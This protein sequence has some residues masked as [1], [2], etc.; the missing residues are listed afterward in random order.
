MKSLLA[1]GTLFFALTFCG[2]TDKIKEQVAETS[3][4]ADGT[5]KPD[6]SSGDNTDTGKTETD[7]GDKVEK[8]N[9]TAKQQEII[10]NG[11]KVVWEEQGMGF[12]LPDGWNKMR[13]GKKMFQYGSPA[14]GFLIVN[15]SSLGQNF[16]TDVS[17]KAFYDQ[18]VQ[19]K[20]DGDV[21]LVRYM[22]IDNIKGVEFIEAMP[23][24]KSSPRRH[25]WI[26]YRNYNNQVQM[27][28]VIIS[29][30]GSKFDARSDTFGAILYSMKFDN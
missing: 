28:N 8:P 19:K 18:H 21:D 1:F 14:K 24:D 4:T 30:D 17:L 26:G 5:T 9:P 11:K 13:V 22:E 20:T 23:E 16:P 12:A 25:Q 29:T 10:D 3:K 15:I 7:S 2:I 27:V 6:N